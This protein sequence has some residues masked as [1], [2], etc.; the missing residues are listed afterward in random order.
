MCGFVNVLVCVLLRA[1]LSV[2]MHVCMCVC[3]HVKVSLI[4]PS[5]RT[6]PGAMPEVPN[7]SFFSLCGA[8]TVDSPPPAGQWEDP[9]VDWGL[10]GGQ[11][12]EEGG[13]D[14]I[15]HCLWGFLGTPNLPLSRPWF[16]GCRP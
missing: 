2:C 16:G 6:A 10:A 15:W 12:E 8:V 3:V 13:Q 14:E 5:Q 11:G 4:S 9:C 7:K 1:C